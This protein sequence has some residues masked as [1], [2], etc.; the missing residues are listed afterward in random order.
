ML[1][2][3]QKSSENGFRKELKQCSEMWAMTEL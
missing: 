3:V 2:K 1:K